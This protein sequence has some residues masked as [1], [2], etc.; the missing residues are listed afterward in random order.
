MRGIKQFAKP[1]SLEYALK[2]L[3][4]H[5]GDA[6]I[7]AG[8]THLALQ[9]QTK[10]SFL[11]DIKELGFNYIK[12]EGDNIKIGAT[13]RPV[14]IINSDLLKEF[15]GGILVEAAS[16]IGSVLTRNL[17]TVGGNVYSMFPWSNL[18]S[19]LLVLDASVELRS[20]DESRIVKLQE[21]LQGNPR[22]FV[23]KNELIT[24]III[25]KSSKNLKTS[26]KVFSLTE[27]DYDIA[28]LAVGL[29]M[30]SSICKGARIALGAAISPCDLLP[31]VEKILENQE[32]SSGLIE[33][34]ANKAIE[35]ISLIKDFRTT[36]QHR[37]DVVKILIKRALEEIRV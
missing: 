29:S 14:D 20:I 25:P 19:A 15:A 7:L 21:L 31:E 5:Q 34:V 18:P 22:K 32:L 27:N 11:I 9:K 36:D 3:H 24:S 23:E 1:T 16:K 8:G 26:Y 4:M 37:I 35:N 28:I 17:V 6:L 10:Y 13:T 30:E 2:M 12:E 33:K